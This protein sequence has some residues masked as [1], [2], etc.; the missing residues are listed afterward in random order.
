MKQDKNFGRAAA[1]VVAG[2]LGF[3]GSAV[4]SV[5]YNNIPAPLPGNVPSLGYQ[6]N[7]TAEFGDLISFGGTDRSLTTVTVLM[8]DWAKH[9]DYAALSAAGYTEPLTLTLYNVGA[10]DTVGSV[11]ST[12]T[13]NSLVPWRPEADPGCGNGGWG[14][15]CYN[16]FAFEVSFDFTGVLVPNSII[17]GL[18]YNTNTWG[19]APNH[20]PGPYESLNFGLAATPPTVGGNP[21]PDT[22]YWNT[23]TASNYTDGGAG[24]IGTFRQDTNWSPYHG[25]VTF[26]AGPAVVPEPASLALFGL[27]LAGLGFSRRKKQ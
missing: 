24:G 23:M 20:A 16:G 18:A 8:S 19:Y 9:S 25:A 1:F 3:G 10:G 22:A 5:I 26:E 27:A 14:A 4:A 11:I 2:V 21:N 17:Y 13:I 15:N 7:Q 12:Q 6:A